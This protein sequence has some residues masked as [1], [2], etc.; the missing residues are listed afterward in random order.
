MN[1]ETPPS[2]VGGAIFCNAIEYRQAVVTF[3]DMHGKQ[4]NGK[5]IKADL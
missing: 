4:K 1:S 5:E 2:S 3:S